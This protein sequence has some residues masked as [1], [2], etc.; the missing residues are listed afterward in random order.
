MPS[1]TAVAALLGG[2]MQL[3]PTLYLCQIR[4]VGTPRERHR[5]Q[6]TNLGDGDSRLEARMEAYRASA[7]ISGRPR[8]VAQWVA[9]VLIAAKAHAAYVMLFVE[10]T[11]HWK[12][13]MR[14]LASGCMC[15]AQRC[16]L[17]VFQVEEVQ[18]RYSL[19][20]SFVRV[21]AQPTTGSIAEQPAWLSQRVVLQ[22]GPAVGAGCPTQVYP[23]WAPV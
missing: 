7:R 1:L 11:R 21:K 8:S 2:G 10:Q 14:D 6:M 17:G 9:L 15:F 22:A 23:P 19:P 16:E 18:A 4:G 13:E 3:V 5:Y 12:D 20:S